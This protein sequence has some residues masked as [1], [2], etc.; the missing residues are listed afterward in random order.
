M[1]CVY[2]VE[3][4]HSEVIMTQRLELTVL[5]ARGGK[6]SVSVPKHKLHQKLDELVGKGWSHE[7]RYQSPL[8]RFPSMVIYHPDATV[9]TGCND[10]V[11]R[12]RGGR[13][14]G[15]IVFLRV[16]DFEKP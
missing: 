13:F 12:P 2:V 8:H 6:F 4:Q 11:W 5:K 3:Q 16:S 10:W 14:F 15:V 1:A 9:H 7:E